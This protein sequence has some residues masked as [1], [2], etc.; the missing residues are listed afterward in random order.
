LLFNSYEFIFLFFP[1]CVLGYFACA[2][3]FSLETALGFLVLGSLFF[4]VW[5]KPAYLILLLF[6]IGFNFLVGRVLCGGIRQGKRWLLALGVAANLGVLCYFKYANILVDNVNAVLG[7][8]WDVGSI[9]LP[10]A[11][12]FF[13]FQQISYL[14][15]A[16]R[17]NTR[18]Y[19][20]LHYSLFV[21]FFPQLLAGPIVR[22]REIMPQ[23]VRREN[24]A[25]GWAN[26]AVG[27]SIFA[28]GLFK[29]TVVAD[30]LAGYVGPVF[31]SR[32]RF[33]PGLGQF[34]GLYLPVVLRLFRL[35]RHGHRGGQGVRRVPAGQFLFAVQV[36]EHY[37][38]LAA[39]AHDPVEVPA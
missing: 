4:Y 19:N 23:L 29:K 6:S 14:V 22:H 20:F 7:T 35:F 10:L 5:W 13:T 34:T 39:V 26:F 18:E 27:L 31:D 17:G 2:R 38:V 12:S 8:Q 11:I 36:H 3:F 37:R 16:Y 9:F 24:M 1:L 30:G 21:C 25:P 28:I 15:D 32:Y 33:F